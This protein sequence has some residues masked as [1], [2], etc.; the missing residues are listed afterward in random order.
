M[1]NASNIFK[2]LL[3]VA[4]AVGSLGTP[5]RADD[6][7]Y[8]QL[9]GTP[10]LTQVVNDLIGYVA[11]DGRIFH[12]FAK[13]D[14][15]SFKTALIAQVCN[16]VGG[17]CAYTGAGLAGDALK[18]ANF[19]DADFNA[20]VEDLEMALDKNHVPIPLQNQLLAVLAPL[21]SAVDYK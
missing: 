21:R 6:R 8:Q 20:L 18:G 2:R 14:I 7:L 9:G 12:Y 15:P 3:I 16:A 13:A 5:A 10:G 17:P 1:V 4:F 19:K 11:A